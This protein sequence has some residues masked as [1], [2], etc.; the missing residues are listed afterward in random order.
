MNGT[1]IRF[2]EIFSILITLPRLKSTTISFPSELVKYKFDYFS[3]DHI[4]K[5]SQENFAQY[6]ELTESYNLINLQ[7]A[8][9][10]NNKLLCSIGLNNLLNKEYSPHTS[11][12]RS[13]A[14]GIPNAGRSYNINLKYE[15]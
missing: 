9:K 3:L 2:P 15:F 11:R 12:I 13:V 8:L 10:F 7:I 5:F 1:E 14:G 6:E 4:C